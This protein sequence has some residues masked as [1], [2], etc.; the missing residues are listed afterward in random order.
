MDNTYFALKKRIRE[1]LLQ[2]W[3]CLFPAP[4]Y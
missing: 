4:G 1:K 3:A 2:E